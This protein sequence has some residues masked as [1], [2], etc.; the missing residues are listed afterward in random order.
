MKKV[1]ALLSAALVPLIL[2][3][4]VSM[5]ELHS[6]NLSEMEFVGLDNYKTVITNG[7]NR[8]YGVLKT[9]ILHLDK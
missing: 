3:T 4:V 2:A 9:R 8:T 7:D 6:T 5:T 1:I